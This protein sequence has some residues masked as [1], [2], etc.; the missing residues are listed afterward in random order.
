VNQ[1]EDK[2]KDQDDEPDMN[3]HVHRW[4]LLKD[5]EFYEQ[6]DLI[7]RYYNLG[8]RAAD[9]PHTDSP[10]VDTIETVAYSYYEMCPLPNSPALRGVVMELMQA[11]G[12]CSF[13]AGMRFALDG[14][15]LD[16]EKF[17]SGE[18]TDQPEDH[19][20][21]K[22]RSEAIHEWRENV[23]N[24][25]YRPKEQIPSDLKAALE[26]F[27]GT[28]LPDGVRVVDTGDGGFGLGIPLQGLGG[29]DDSTEAPPGTG[30]YL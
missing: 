15:R 2:S 18:L 9:C 12:N 26:K 30:N 28:K 10:I 20:W 16:S 17:M 7:A 21:N 8:S 14:N 6:G 11:I 19:A 22:E 29:H 27:M 13:A 3:A 5:R 23:R 25:H 24:E 1:N 4:S